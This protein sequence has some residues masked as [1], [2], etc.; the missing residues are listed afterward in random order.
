MYLLDFERNMDIQGYHKKIK[1]QSLPT[2]F[3][4]FRE[5]DRMISSIPVNPHSP[6]SLSCDEDDDDL[7]DPPPLRRGYRVSMRTKITQKVINVLN[8]LFHSR[9]KL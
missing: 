5:L 4:S 7:P 9:H 3:R 8:G 2:E 1:M 6:R